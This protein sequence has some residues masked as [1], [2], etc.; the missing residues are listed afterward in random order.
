MPAASRVDWT[1]D[2]PKVSNACWALGATIEELAAKTAM[3][4][5][6]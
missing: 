5:V 4:H 3:Q 1:V 2:F 6:A